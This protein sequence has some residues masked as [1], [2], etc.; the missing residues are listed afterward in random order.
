[1]QFALLFFVNCNAVVGIHSLSNLV[2][3]F[4]QCSGEKD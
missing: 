3:C 2:F 1:M 4:T